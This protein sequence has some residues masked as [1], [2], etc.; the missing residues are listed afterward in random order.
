MPSIGDIIEGG[1]GNLIGGA[2]SQFW[3]SLYQ[4]ILSDLYTTAYKGCLKTF[5]GLFDSLNDNVS[6]AA[7][8]LVRTPRAWNAS[9]YS[10]VRDLSQ[11]AFLPV[12]AVFLAVVFA[13]EMAQIVQNSNQS[14]QHFKPDNLIFPFLKLALCL[15]A[16]SHA[17]EIIMLFFRIGQVVTQKISGTA[18]G[19][20]GE[21]LEFANIVS[22]SLEHYELGD[23]VEVVGYSLILKLAKFAVWLIGIIIY[24]RVIFWF[25]E[26]YVMSC[27]APIPYAMWMNKEWQQV[28][29]NYTRKMLAL[30]FQGPLMLML[31]AIYGGVLGGLPIGADFIG[32][33]GMIIGSAFTLGALLFKTSAIADSIFAAH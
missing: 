17:F 24:I 12:A 21:G 9:A 26:I 30:M 22:P 27:A 15:L 20:F 25:L 3:D 32:S 5:N 7:E 14:M 16:C 23:V 33:L 28:S 8:S 19:S 29:V 2:F 13:W 6:D 11:T 18:I 31:Y 10:M 4:T 1:E